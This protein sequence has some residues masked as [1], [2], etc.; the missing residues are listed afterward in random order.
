MHMTKMLTYTIALLFVL[1]GCGSVDTDGESLQ[2]GV[3]DS[4]DSAETDSAESAAEEQPADHDHAERPEVV[5]HAHV[6]RL[7]E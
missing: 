4:T 6:P 5:L 1:A 3:E 2:D 7:P